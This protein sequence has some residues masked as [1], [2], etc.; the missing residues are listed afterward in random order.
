MT[1][2][3]KL[4]LNEIEER[5]ADLRKNNVSDKEIVDCV[6]NALAS[7]NPNPEEIQE[8]S[9]EENGT[10]DIAD[11][12]LSLGFATHVK[13]F[14]YLKT[15]LPM[16]NADRSLLGYITKELYPSVARAHSTTPS[17]VERGIRHSIEIA[18]ERQNDLFVRYFR[19]R[20]TNA[21][22]MATVVE[23]IM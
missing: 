4:F 8:K 12:L 1:K 17:R 7:L 13:G 2:E 14:Q 19:T 9:S 15:A 18:W 10:P 11:L 20:P 23:I 6:I 16:I 22:F 5:I 21:E 3:K